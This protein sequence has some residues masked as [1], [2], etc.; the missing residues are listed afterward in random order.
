MT[1]TNTKPSKSLTLLIA[2][3]LLL[4]TSAS[5]SAGTDY[6]NKI[7]E[8][9][10][11]DNGLS[12]TELLHKLF[13][14]SWNHRMQTF[15]EWATYIGYPGQNDRWTDNSLEGFKLRH[16]E[17]ELPLLILDK[18]NRAGL[19]DED[20]LN[21]DLFSERIAT[22]KDGSRFRSELMPINQR[23]GIQQDAA[24]LLAMMPTNSI[25]D[26]NDILA[27]L[28]GVTEQVDQTISRL[29]EGLKKGLTP[30]RVTMTEVPQQVLN[31]ITEIPAEAPI[32]KALLKISD[33]VSSEEQLHIRNQAYEIYTGDIV[34][35][36]NK[37][38]QFLQFQ[39]LPSCREEV[40]WSDLPDGKEWYEYLCRYYTTTDLSP[41]SIYNIGISEVA[42]IRAEMD[43][44][45]ESVG[46]DGDF[47][48]FCEFLRTDP[49]FYFTTAEELLT[50]YRDIC[51]RAD[52]E[53][54]KLFSYLPRLP[55]GV[56]PIPSYAE[57]SQTT[58]YYMGGS[59]EAGRPGIF[60]ANTYGLDTRPTWE[61]EA[62]SLHEA[63]PGHHFQISIAQE[64]TGLPEFR[65]RGWYTAYG[66]GWGL[67]SESLGEEMGFYKDP[68]SKF[69]QLTY[70][71][72][73][74]IRLVVDVGLHTKGWSRAK[75]I[76]FFASN[77]SKQLHDIEVEINRYI[78]NPAQALAY[79]IGELK[80]KE[81]RAYAV[82]TLGEKFDIRTF[83]DEILGNGPLP[84]AVLDKHMR[85]WVAA[86]N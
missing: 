43:K 23:R 61:M 74:A 47:A 7:Q 22:A 86:Q 50:E 20:K 12:D 52:P 39:Y 49:Q 3:T 59:A 45:I 13:E 53:L 73:R 32:L 35:A 30:P 71:I 55:Y 26:L 38:H 85:E 5:V 46:F 79:K 77:S 2:C 24:Q 9:A 64:L 69:G 51:K 15:P 37:L 29:K 84:L 10:K 68:Y 31:Q 48:A 16:S 75:A 42:R 70:E 6:E 17:I 65:K 81:L 27:R 57:K 80:I 28:K 58:A 8:L 33:M 67:Y 18:I 63:V 72:W 19:S 82:E 62:L 1:F 36:F 83:H 25:S 41:D 21:F 44:V 4:M 11:N 78:N 76:K 60:F 66:E 56:E 54:I 14:L 34:P 40:G